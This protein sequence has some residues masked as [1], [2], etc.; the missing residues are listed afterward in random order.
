MWIYIGDQEH[1]FNLFHYTRGRSRE[2]PKQFLKRFNRFLQG[3]CFSG[4]EGICAEFGAILVA[5]NAHARHYFTKALL[6]YRTKSEEAMRLFQQLFKIEDVAKDLEL[7]S[8]DV[9]LMREQE[10]KPILDELKTWLDR[11]HVMALP[12]SAFGKAVSYSLNNW[13][14]LTAYL[15]DGDLSIDNNIAEQEMKRVAMG[16]KAWLFFGSDNGGERAEVLLSLVSTCKR[17]KVEPWAYLKDVIEQLT[18]NPDT[19]LENLLPHN[20]K[21]NNEK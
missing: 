4:N 9:K 1:P 8:A 6:N 13:E 10:S 15:A 18:Q 17:H 14:A 20:W 16:R 3:D 12:K 21:Q 19:D 7:T 11:E 2:G 5:C